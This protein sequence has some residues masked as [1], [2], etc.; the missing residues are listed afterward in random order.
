MDKFEAL[1][2]KMCQELETLEQKM[3]GGSDMTMQDL[4]KVD[5]LSHALKSLATYRA[6]CEAEEYGEGMSGRRGRGSNGRYMS[7]DEGPR[8]YDGG[9]SGH[10][11]PP[12][13][14]ERRY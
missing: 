8:S 14:P 6:M 13:W 9:Y 1:E 10:Y 12:W 2:K 3:K 5:K 11:P 4:E 7:M